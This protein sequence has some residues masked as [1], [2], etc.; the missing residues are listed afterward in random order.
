MNTAL[1]N[2]MYEFKIWLMLTKIQFTKEVA[3]RIKIVREQKGL[4]QE[5]LADRAGL[6]RTYI[7]H[8]EN[9]RYSPSSYVVYKIAKALK[10]S[11]SD[12]I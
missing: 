6:Y 4:S 9:A 12:I 2:T 5:E 10:V 7:G 8:L 3:K 1:S 11:V